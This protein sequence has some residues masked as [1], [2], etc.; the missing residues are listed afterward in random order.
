M[1]EKL[2]ILP[3]SG[4]FPKDIAIFPDSK[5][6]V[7]LNHESDTMS[8]FDLNFKDKVIVMNGPMIK[9]PKGNCIIM[10]QL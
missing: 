1:L 5:H 4:D 8:F 2:F 9:V 10:K 3:V 7:S 6:L